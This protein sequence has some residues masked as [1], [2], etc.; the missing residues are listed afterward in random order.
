[1]STDMWIV[2][3]CLVL[4]CQLLRLEYEIVRRLHC[5]L[6]EYGTNDLNIS[7][8]EVINVLFNKTATMYL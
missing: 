7:F 5:A 4:R 3:E 2:F 8:N 1:M 6:R